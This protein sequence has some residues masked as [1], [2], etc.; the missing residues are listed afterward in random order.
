MPTQCDL[1]QC[2]QTNLF[3]SITTIQ[4]VMTPDN[5]KESHT[6]IQIHIKIP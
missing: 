6:H 2:N 5:A 3:E 1:M 4:I